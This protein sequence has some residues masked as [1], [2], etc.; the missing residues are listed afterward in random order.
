MTYNTVENLKKIPLTVPSGDTVYLEDVANVYTTTDSSSSIA[1]Y[2]GNDTISVSI[3]KQ[4]SAT[5]ME[6]SNQVKKTIS[7]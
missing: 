4:Q 5:A 6:L 2:D 3:S 7:V 1:R